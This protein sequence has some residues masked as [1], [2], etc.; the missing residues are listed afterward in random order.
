MRL[1]RRFVCPRCV[2]SDWQRGQRARAMEELGVAQGM[3]AATPRLCHARF[4]GERMA[5]AAQAL[6]AGDDRRADAG[7][8]QAIARLRPLP[9]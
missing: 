3:L 4:A 6:A 8:A 7:L 5:A 1:A 9:R 2:E